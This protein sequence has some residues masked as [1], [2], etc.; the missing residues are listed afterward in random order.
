MADPCLPVAI[1]PKQI[2]VA[3]ILEP[4]TPGEKSEGS[5][6]PSKR[7]RKD[8]VHVPEDTDISISTNKEEPQD[9]VPI[10]LSIKLHKENYRRR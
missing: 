10:P 2:D 6:P 7:Q 5:M 9:E 3:S 4:N 8:P 1:P